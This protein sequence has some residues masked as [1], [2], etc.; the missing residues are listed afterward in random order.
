MLSFFNIV[1]FFRG[2]GLEIFPLGWVNPLCTTISMRMSTESTV[3]RNHC[4][5]VAITLFATLI[6]FRLCLSTTVI[7]CSFVYLGELFVVQLNVK[8]C[9]AGYYL[10]RSVFSIVFCCIDETTQK[11]FRA[12]DVS[13]GT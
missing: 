4:K 10:W 8:V 1:K 3:Q 11:N 7:I 12:G 13:G 6:F 2:R 9:F 5:F